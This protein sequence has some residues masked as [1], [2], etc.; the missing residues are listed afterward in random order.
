VEHKLRSQQGFNCYPSLTGYTVQSFDVTPW[1]ITKNT[2][3]TI[4]MSG[5][6]NSDEQLQTLYV[7]TVGRWIGQQSYPLTDYVKAGS[8]YNATASSWLPA[9]MPPGIYGLQLELENTAGQLLNCWQVG[10][11]ISPS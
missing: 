10:F 8:T 6:M 9:Y 2:T 5:I 7:N 1:P 4:E 3:V 11:Q